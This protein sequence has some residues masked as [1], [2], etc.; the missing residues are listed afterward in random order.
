MPF[1]VGEELVVVD[2]TL[3]ASGGKKISIS[4]TALKGLQS[5]IDKL[6]ANERG[7]FRDTFVGVGGEEDA[8]NVDGAVLEWKGVRA[9]R[10]RYAVGKLAEQKEELLCP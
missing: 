2:C 7:P 5:E 1:V 3:H 6:G 8:F 10:T 9:D 4:D